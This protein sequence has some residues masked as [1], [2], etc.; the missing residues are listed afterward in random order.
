MRAANSSRRSRLA[1]VSRS[2]AWSDFFSAADP[3]SSTDARSVPSSAKYQHRCATW[4][5]VEPA[6]DQASKPP[7]PSPDA[8]PRHRPAAYVQVGAAPARPAPSA[9]VVRKSSS[10]SPRSQ[11]SDPQV[12]PAS[13]RRGRRTT[14]TYGAD[15]PHMASPFHSLAAESRQLKSTLFQKRL[16]N[17][18][19]HMLQSVISNSRFA[20]FT[21]T[22][23]C[24]VHAPDV[25]T[26]ALTQFAENNPPSLHISRAETG[27]YWLRK[28][29]R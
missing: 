14:E 10:P 25:Q 28:N 8:A 11:G 23:V 21:N 20:A 4:P 12:P 1:S 18:G 27:L 5:A 26:A 19:S 2:T 22:R 6:S 3:T 7:N 13:P 9:S 15:H 29:S 16:S 24:M 17:R